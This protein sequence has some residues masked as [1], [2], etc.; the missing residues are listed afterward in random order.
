VRRSTVKCRGRP[1]GVEGVDFPAR[2]MSTPRRVTGACRGRDGQR[3]SRRRAA[4]RLRRSRWVFHACWTAAIR[5]M[6]AAS[7]VAGRLPVPKCSTVGPERWRACQP[8]RPPRGAVRLDGAEQF[9]GDDDPVAVAAVGLDDLDGG[10]LVVGVPAAPLDRVSL[11]RPGH[12]LG[13]RRHRGGWGAG[14]G[15][16]WRGGCARLVD[17]GRSEVGCAHRLGALAVER[18]AAGDGRC[19]HRGCGLGEG[20]GRRDGRRDG[21]LGGGLVDV[22]GLVPDRRGRGGR[23]T[24]GGWFVVLQRPVQ[25]G[26]ADAE[27]AGDLGDGLAA[28]AAGAGGGPSP[29]ASASPPSTWARSPTEGCSSSSLAARCRRWTCSTSPRNHLPRRRTSALAREASVGASPGGLIPLHARAAAPH[30]AG[31]PPDSDV[32]AHG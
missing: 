27:L 17:R 8:E 4:S 11:A 2:K 13:G 25:R 14:L 12:A 24:Q 19:G 20:L 31:H 28:C 5:S 9:A 7:R 21:G 26:A 22:D 3:S 15:A 10:Q 29:A 16:A 18:L 1:R 30:T 32:R 23:G 6:T